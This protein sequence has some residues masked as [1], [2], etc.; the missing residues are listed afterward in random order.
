MKVCAEPGCPELQPESR[1][2]THTRARDTARGTRQQRGYGPEH[3]AE[4]ARWAPIVEAGLASCWRCGKRL[5]PGEPWDTGHDDHDRTKYRGPECLPCNR[6]TAGRR[7]TPPPEPRNGHLP[8]ALPFGIP[9][10]GT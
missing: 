9:R 4:R 1:C 6:A 8:S 3:D 7:A 5:I 10:R 2:H